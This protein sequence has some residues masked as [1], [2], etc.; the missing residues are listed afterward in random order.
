MSP[1]IL[2]L[3]LVPAVALSLSWFAGS[4]M[5]WSRAPDRPLAA[6]APARDIALKAADGVPLAATFWP[7]RTP[8]APGILLL[9]GI[10]ASRQGYAPQAAWLAQQ[11][12]AVLTLDLRG[13]GGSG[14]GAHS[15]GLT[16]SQ[17]ARAAFDWLKAKQ[18]GAPIGV[19]G[20]SLGGAAALIGDGG[21]LPA[22]GFVLVCVY[23]DID[24]AIR[25]RIAAHAPEPL[26]TLITPLLKYQSQPRFGVPPERLRPIE[27]LRG[28]KAP[29]LI[30]G[31]GADAYTPP[32]ESREMLAAASGPKDLLLLDGMDHG[33]ATWADTPAYR[34]RLKQFFITALGAP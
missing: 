18:H 5:V 3:A 14:N 17:D 7:G 23:P 13:H 10:F 29:V 4:A 19:I 22:Q 34:E 27:A 24:N 16:E 8:D 20:I 26:P 9:H 2:G 21:P 32:S 25:N 6:A 12:F 11:G 15:F 1:T 31:G 30:V 28:V 33:A